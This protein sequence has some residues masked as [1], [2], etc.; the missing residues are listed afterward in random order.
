MKNKVLKIIK[1]ILPILIGVYLTWYFITNAISP[2]KR[3]FFLSASNNEIESTELYTGIFTS[4]ENKT[5]QNNLFR[6]NFNYN[7]FFF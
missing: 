3:S 2:E 4:I 1:I 7:S 6:D 5:P